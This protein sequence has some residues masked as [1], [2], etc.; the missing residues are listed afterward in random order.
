M[1]SRNAGIR[2]EKLVL[3]LL[4]KHG[5]LSQVDLCRLAGLNSST[6]SYI[7]GRLREK[8]IILEKPGQSRRRG[9]K[10]V[11]VSAAP[12]SRFVIG[13]EI[14]PGNL[15]L[16]LFD[17]YCTLLDGIKIPLR[18]EQTPAEVV[19]I[20]DV[21][22]RGLLARRQIDAERL[23]GIGVTLSGS[24][25]P[26]GVVELSSPLGWKAVPLSEMLQARLPAPVHVYTTRVRLLAENSAKPPLE[27]NHILY[28]QV[29]DGV[30]GHMVAD[31][32]LL[33]GATNRAGELG[34]IVID[35]DGPLCGCGQ[36]GC[37]EAFI[38]GPALMRRIL[39][40]LDAGRQTILRDLI[41]PAESA[42]DFVG[43]WAEALRRGDPYALEIQSLVADCLSRAAVIAINCFDPEVVI[44]G[45]YV[46]AACVEA[47]IDAI[48]GRMK[49]EVY[50]SAAR[51]VQ[52][53]AARVG[54]EALIQGAA[55][56]VI[57][58]SLSL[59]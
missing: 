52:I 22:T 58:E 6:A 25:S 14:G 5:E 59:A 57:Q 30:G 17:F 20:L 37:V 27:S 16:G 41:Q 34:H 49:R 45:G 51:R 36:R 42:A 8:G 55:A 10:P 48:R 21:N 40:D 12:Q 31:G 2:N 53:I 39:A 56:A 50:D 9:A 15:F 29:G 44:L 13:V 46:T 24:V 43:H 26:T 32:R 47:L 23:L 1:D 11:I 28:L 3:S 54:K 33:H 18:R 7:I 38:S 4:L 19:E 35:P